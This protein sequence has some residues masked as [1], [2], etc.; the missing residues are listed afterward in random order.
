M[1]QAIRIGT[2][3]LLC[4]A[5]AACG[6]RPEP[7]QSQ[8]SEPADHDDS[9]AKD[10][11]A[12]DSAAKDSA[13]RDSAAKD[14]AARDSAAKD[15]AAKDSAAKDSAGDSPV[16]KSSTTKSQ[17][18]SAKHSA[19]EICEKVT[20]RASQKC[21]K[22]IAGLYQSSCNHYLKNLGQ[23][24]EEIRVALECHYQA[25][26]ESFCAHEVD[27]KCSKVNR[28]LKACQRGT[29]PAEQETAAD[30]PVP[31]NWEKICDTQ[32]GFTVAMP[33]GAHLDDKSKRRTWEAKENGVA[34]Y[35]AELEPPRGK[36]SNPVYV[37]T[38]IAYVGARCQ[39]HLKLHG[40]LETKGTTVVQYHSG[41]PDG[42]EWHGMLHFYNGKVISTGAHAPAGRAGVG[43][44]FFYSLQLN[45]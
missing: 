25:P 13:A 42:S 32:L 11:A 23:C 15:S 14:S 43:E 30:H 9:A 24:E 19:G 45:K 16:S 26:D 4:C 44:P 39:Q 31:S 12:K 3:V 29:A 38:V 17:A 41:C 35:V 5:S 40:E 36:L 7:R 34:Y 1:R 6:P 22:Q 37:R 21:T 2:T 8:K 18:D 20:R 27:Q 33:T 10:S 28:E